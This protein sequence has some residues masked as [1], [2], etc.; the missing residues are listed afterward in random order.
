MKFL[1]D[2]ST[3][4]KIVIYLRDKGYDVV[5]VAEKLKGYSD[6]SIL[7]FANEQKCI[8][9]TND[10]DFGELIYRHQYQ[11]EGVIFLRLQD[12]RFSNKVRVLENVL[13]MFGSGVSGA[14]IVASESKMRRRSL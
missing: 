3:G 11:C 8:V 12:E 7:K 14:F 9:I 13:K 6:Q 2:E 10:K 5:S 1:V 4:Q